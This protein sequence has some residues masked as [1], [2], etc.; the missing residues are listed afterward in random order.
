M[1]KKLLT[2]LALLITGIIS[3]QVGI[4]TNDPKSGLEINT[5]LGYKVTTITSATTL[6]D[7]CILIGDDVEF[8]NSL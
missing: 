1:K 6:E 3:A 2:F 5:S 7:T 4:G 8:T